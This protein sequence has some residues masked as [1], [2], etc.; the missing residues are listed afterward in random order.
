MKKFLPVFCLFIGLQSTS[1]TALEPFP[2]WLEQ[3]KQHAITQ[4]ISPQIVAE[5]LN[6]LTPDEQV[7]AL[8]QKQPESTKTFTQYLGDVVNANR[9][10]KGREMMATYRPLLN[11]IGSAYGVQPR[12]IVALWGIETNYGGYTGNM[13]VIN[14]LATLAWEGRRR[15]FFTEEL[16]N[17]LRIVQQGHITA[18]AMDGSWAGAMGQCQFMPSSFLNFAVDYN[19]NGRKN[20]WG[21]LPDVFAS[22]ANYLKQSGWSD[23]L[24]WG[25]AVQLPRNFDPKL[26]DGKTYLSLAEW[27]RLGV[28]KADG[29]ALPNRSLEAALTLPGK[30]HE[31]A[32]IIYRNYDVLLKWNRSRYFATAV[33][34]LSDA[35]R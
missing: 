32:Y 18:A 3:F 24:T 1:A 20:I 14:S 25:R 4:G 7:I 29:S 33:G 6:G 12:F 5:S 17:A 35:L 34:T 28:R 31:Q 23:E 19:R 30:P 11:E 13:S 22:I 21:E 10:R 16:L 8:D 27:Q 2:Q 26:T 15:D 9:I